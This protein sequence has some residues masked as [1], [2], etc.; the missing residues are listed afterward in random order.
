MEVSCLNFFIS[1]TVFKGYGKCGEDKTRH[2]STRVVFD[3]AQLNKL[4]VKPFFK[5]ETELVNENG[6]VTGWEVESRKRSIQDDKPVHLAAAI[7]QH[8]KVLLLE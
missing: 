3:D 8:S 6:E 5:N 7:L 1:L 2:T 4:M